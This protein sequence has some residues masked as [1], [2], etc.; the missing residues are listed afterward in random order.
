VLPAINL[1]IPFTGRSPSR[2]ET[3]RNNQSVSPH[4]TDRFS[5]SIIVFD[6]LIFDLLGMALVALCLAG[7][8]APSRRPRSRAVSDF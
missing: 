1:E 8:V 7:M 2:G 3:L 5:G 6:N 4:F